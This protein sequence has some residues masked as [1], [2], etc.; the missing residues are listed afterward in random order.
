MTISLND[1]KLVNTKINLLPYKSE[2]VDDWIPITEAGG[3]CDSYATAK[4]ERLFLMGWPNNFLRFA[5]CYVEPFK[6]IDEITGELRDATMKERCHLVL[7]VDWDGQ[8]WVL[9]NRHPLP[10]EFNLLPYKWHL[11]QVA[12]T[13]N[14]EKA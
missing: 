13:Q 10:I 1:L 5:I 14:W 6:L 9:D 7:L 3:D 4:F 2:P 12:G 11:L 8:T